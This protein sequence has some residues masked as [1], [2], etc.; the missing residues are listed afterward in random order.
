[1]TDTI[2]SAGGSVIQG[3]V[4]AGRDF[5]GRDQY[6]ITHIYPQ[7]GAAP[8]DEAA[9][10]EAQRR[11]AE[12]PLDTIPG[13]APLPAGLQDALCPQPAVRGPGGGFATAGGGAAGSDRDGPGAGDETGAGLCNELGIHLR[14]MGNYAGARRYYERTLAIF[15]Q[16]LGPDHPNSRV[17]RGNLASL[18]G[19][20]ESDGG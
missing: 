8:V 11:L 2:D 15:E 14:Q 7:A 12:M 16:A 20:P 18:E 9:L 5:V 13:P 10:A 4:S 1:M 17:V 19:A 3:A 6:N